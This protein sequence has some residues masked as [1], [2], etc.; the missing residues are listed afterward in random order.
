M[1]VVLKILFLEIVKGDVIW[2]I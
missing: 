2:K 1:R